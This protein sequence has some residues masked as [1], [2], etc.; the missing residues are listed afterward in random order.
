MELFKKITK[1]VADILQ[2]I[3]VVGALAVF[4]YGFVVQP[5][6]VSGSS[7][8]PTFKDKEYVLS[9]LLAARF[10]TLS[11]GNV[12]VFHSPIEAEKSYIKRV[13]ATAGDTVRVE[14]GKVFLNNVSLDESTYIGP[15]VQ[16]FGGAFM[17]EGQNVTV[18]EGSILVM[19][20]NRPFSSDSREWGFLPEDKIIGHSIIR[21]YPVKNF[22]II[23]HPY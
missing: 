10:R 19:G 8:F 17:Q 18:P 6:E 9:N 3:V 4:L 7:M 21:I 12:V 13:I 5:H 22:T 14:N 16:T 15:E 11:K 23:P 20:D 2:A 1:I